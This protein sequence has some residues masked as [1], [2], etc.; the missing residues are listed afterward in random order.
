VVFI[1]GTH[2]EIIKNIPIK[3]KLMNSI[4]LLLTIIL[5]G[6]LFSSCT[7]EN[8]VPFVEIVSEYDLWYVD[9]NRTSGSGDIPYISKAFT[10]SFLDG[11]LYANNNIVDIGR[12]GNGLGIDVGTYN[13]FNGI[14]ETYHDLDGA[15]D[16][17]ITV[18]S[19]N[20]IK[21]YNFRQNVSYYLIGYQVNQF[22]YDKL[23]YE[24]IEYFLQE[25]VAWEK[26]STTG[27][28]PNAFDDENYLAFSPEN[29]T[30]FY[31][32]QDRFGRQT[33]AIDWDYV[34]RY[35]LY[36]VLDYED[37][38]IL[39]LTY[40]GGDLEEFELSIISDGKI[41]LYNVDSETTYEFS[42]K[43]FVQYLKGGKSKKEAKDIVRNANR[44][45]TKV[46]RKI[47]TRRNLK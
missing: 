6:I 9:Y 28:I 45:R 25:Y 38:K 1:F 36:D 20:E 31:S 12:T 11:I 30:T 44:K 41:A 42:G 3:L 22:N 17:E 23:F 27:G 2:F 37:L 33:A 46:I 26:V 18:I 16:F 47:K 15:N 10:L 43:G 19:S 4:K 14:L 5:S 13:T 24:N 35:D 7:I 34:G 32:S 39:T 29:T 40:E 21:I 8:E